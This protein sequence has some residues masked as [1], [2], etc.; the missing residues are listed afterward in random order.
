MCS[1]AQ[2]YVKQSMLNSPVFYSGTVNGNGVFISDTNHI[3]FVTA[4]RNLFSE[5][6]PYKLISKQATLSFYP[7]N[8][9][10]DTAERISIDVKEAYEKNFIKYDSV[11]DIAII[12]I[13]SLKHNNA[14]SGKPD[15]YPFVLKSEAA[16][17]PTWLNERSEAYNEVEVGAG[18]YLFNYPLSIG[19]QQTNQF[20]YQ[21]PLI[22]RGEISGKYK[23][24]KNIIIHAPAYIGN[25]GGPV[26]ESRY[27]AQGEKISLIGI[28][29]G[30]IPALGS[31]NSPNLGSDYSIVVP[32][33]YVRNLMKLFK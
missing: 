32:M 18:V 3:Y 26:Y 28:V 9:F 29:T 6:A 10:S 13:A 16:Y 22:R 12:L 19:L 31:S 8:V 30:P 2:E 14:P 5:K 17:L 25:T 4:R 33:D 21:R 23:K 11:N 15:F 20:D 24:L 1:H 27:T 7:L